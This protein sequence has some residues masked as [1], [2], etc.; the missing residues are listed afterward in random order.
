LEA[1]GIGLVRVGSW[2]NLGD[3]LA[4]LFRKQAIDHVTRRLEG[5][6]VLASP[7][8]QRVLAAILVGLTVLVLLF[9]VFATYTRRET[10]SGWIVPEGGLIRVAARQ[11]GLVMAL[12]V[13]EGAQV[14][15]GAPLADLRLSPDLVGG[16]AGQALEQDL[17]AEAAA[18][19]AQAEASRAK[20]LAQRGEMI[21]RRGV[22]AR[23]LTE[24]RARIGAMQARQQLADTQVARALALQ[25][26]G[27]LAAQAVEQLKSSALS[28]AQDASQTRGSALDVER[29]ISDID[30]ELRGVPA[31]LAGIAAQAAQSEAG[32]SQR[33]TAAR[34][35]DTIV[36]TAPVAGRVVAIPVAVGQAVSPGGAVVVLTPK[37][38]D[39]NAELYVPSKAIGF[40][41]P[42]QPVRLMYQ[43]FPYQTFGAGHGVVSS[44]SETVLAPSEVAIPGLAVAEPVFRV[45]VKLDHAW[46]DAYGR[47][48]LLQPGMLLTADVVTDRRSLL[49]WLLDPLYAVGRRT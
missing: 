20:L 11:G 46:V 38:S 8:P 12:R 40:I 1:A 41:R 13:R 35:Q 25:Q 18:A 21:S 15:A 9:A 14:A 49:Q 32:V 30:G 2:A 28:A 19:N 7:L 31:D 17:S 24:L 44:V 48:T 4:E 5:D 10:V 37:G 23:E 39:L 34:T 6:V 29:Q 26:K 33:L 42:G 45:R 36:A 27:F 16:D 47:S 22:L 3:A 43:A